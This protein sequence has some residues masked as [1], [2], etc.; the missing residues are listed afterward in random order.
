MPGELPRS[1]VNK[2]KY[3][4]RKPHEEAEGL[5]SAETEKAY[6]HMFK[7]VYAQ[8]FKRAFNEAFAL[9]V[10]SDEGRTVIDQKTTRQE[11]LI[12]KV[13]SRF[14]TYLRGPATNVASP[15]TNTGGNH[16]TR[17]SRLSKLYNT[18]C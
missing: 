13:Q 12:H 10:A 15:L 11:I 7:M 1:C 5:A 17:R 14:T 9:A 8:E 6:D 4:V 3:R 16:C 2:T 18:V